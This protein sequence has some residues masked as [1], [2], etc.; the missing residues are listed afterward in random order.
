MTAPP[1]RYPVPAF[2]LFNV[3]FEQIYD[4][5]MTVVLSFGGHVYEDVLKTA[6]MRLIG[7]NPYIRSKF[8]VV[9]GQPVWEEIPE[10]EWERAFAL[11][12]SGEDD[13]P[14][15]AVLPPAPDVRAGPQ[16]RVTVYRGSGGDTV[17]V[18]CHH[19]FC[20]AK[21]LLTMAEDLCSAYRGVM[22]DPGCRPPSTGLYDRTTD[23][24]L[25]LYTDE[26]CRLA[27]AE[28]E[29]FVDRWHF[30]AE[31]F[32]YGIQ[33]AAYRTLPEERLARMKA[34]GKEYGA[35]VN[36]VLIA[37]FFL[38]FLA[39]RDDPADRGAPRGIL[40]S[41][42]MRRLLP[43]NERLPPMN[44]SVAFELTLSVD[45]RAT[46]PDILPEVTA[47]MKSKKD[48][49]IG[50]GCIHFY[51]E[52][53]A[54]GMEAVNAFFDGMIERYRTDG[55]KNPVFA[56]L[57]VIN[58]DDYL[59]MPGKD[60]TAL[61]LE[62]FNFIPCICWPYG[63]LVT[64]YTFRGALTLI[65]AYEEGPYSTETVERFLEYMDGYLQV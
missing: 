52:I 51:E 27:I 33:K 43:G 45:F 40:T 28:E 29:P 22:Q 57:G 8:A 65:T 50:P 55:E 53:Y 13:A 35:T 34:I 14:P 23:R 10:D 63:F 5:A 32:G 12:H 58:P 19:G 36:D 11:L 54:G 61:S 38:A 18:T 59:P 16:I 37:A 6:T 7:S 41:A 3:L 64:A 26:E 46:L 4:P 30:P 47:F 56:N 25:S 2:D 49:R 62:R 21:G 31:R 15:P 39:I 42:D 44:L 48:G 60:G 9:D 1:H 17:C 24:I 20:D